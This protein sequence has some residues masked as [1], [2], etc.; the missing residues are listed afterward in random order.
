MLC[1]CGSSSLLVP[2]VTRAASRRARSPRHEPSPRRRAPDRRRRR[3]APDVLHRRLGPTRSPTARRSS[4]SSRRPLLLSERRDRGLQRRGRARLAT[5]G[6]L[7]EERRRARLGYL[8]G[9]HDDSHRAFA[10]HHKLPFHLVERSRSSSSLTSSACASKYI[11]KL[12]ATIEMRETIVIE[13]TATSEDPCEPSILDEVRRGDR[14][15]SRSS[16]RCT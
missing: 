1:A 4:A 15:E 8:L 6:T 11:D 12:G 7:P 9:R 16:A 5:R 10:E 14:A 2:I 3:A 13:R